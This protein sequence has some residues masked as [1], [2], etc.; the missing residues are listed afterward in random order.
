MGTASLRISKHRG[1]RFEEVEP[2][3]SREWITVRGESGLEWTDARNAARDAWNRLG[4][5]AER[6]LPGDSDRDGK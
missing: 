6:V 3:L 1:R 4:D 2:E 5:S